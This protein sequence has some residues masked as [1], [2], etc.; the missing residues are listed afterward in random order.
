MDVFAIAEELSAY[1]DGGAIEEYRLVSHVGSTRA[2]ALSATGR[3]LTRDLVSGD[4]VTAQIQ[5]F[6]VDAQERHEDG[7]TA[8]LYI[9]IRRT[10]RSGNLGTSR[11][12]PVGGEDARAVLTDMRD[13][14]LAA[15]IDVI[16]GTQR[17]LSDLLKH[18]I[19]KESE[20]ARSEKELAISLAQMAG[21]AEAG[22]DSARWQSMAAAAEHLG[23]AL[24]DAV[25]AWRASQGAEGQI[26]PSTMTA[27]DLADLLRR[28]PASAREAIARAIYEQMRA[29][30]QGQGGEGA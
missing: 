5:R 12:I 15:A 29:A 26:D 2:D 27:E 19:S 21:A 7:P 4:N 13:R 25:G 14:A 11:P 23:P 18:F 28:A 6:I 17:L 1:V 24:R 20:V 3:D 22:D 10:G 16:P 30:E 9:C 8:Y